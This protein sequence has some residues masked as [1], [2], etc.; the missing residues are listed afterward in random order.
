MCDL[1]TMPQ[2]F[3]HK[4]IVMYLRRVMRA[5]FAT[6]MNVGLL[7]VILAS[8]CVSTGTYDKKVKVAE[9]TKARED[10]AAASKQ[11]EQALDEKISAV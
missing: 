4:Q 10:D 7:L 2:S 3:E 6:S 11:R 5:V 8:A 9:L 1:C